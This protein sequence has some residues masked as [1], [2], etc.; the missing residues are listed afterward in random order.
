MSTHKDKKLR[1]NEKEIKSNE[2]IL[3][4]YSLPS[5]VPLLTVP[6]HLRYRLRTMQETSEKA[7]RAALL[8]N[9]EEAVELNR[10]ILRD[11]PHD[12][13]AL[14]RLGR[15]YMQLGRTEDALNTYRRVLK[16]DRYN[17]IAT[18]S[19]KRLKITKQPPVTQTSPASPLIRTDFLEEPGRTKSTQLVRPADQEIIATLHVGQPVTLDAKRRSVSVN[20]EDG[21]YIGSLPDD[22]SYRLIRLMRAGNKYE[23][24][25]KGIPEPR[26]VQLFI[27][28]KQRS[29]RLQNLPSFPSGATSYQAD[30]RPQILEEVPLDTRETGEEEDE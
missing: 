12:I 15:A 29:K 10:L 23:A 8:G 9:W 26:G 3:T 20:L 16:H 21:T 19:L 1:N 6:F 22:L 25:V 18:K 17:P 5:S 7:I 28:E 30:L 13:T 14:N 27:R 24:L 11:Y 2:T 4:H